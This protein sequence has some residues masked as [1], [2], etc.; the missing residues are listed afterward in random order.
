MSQVTEYNP[1]K[2]LWQHPPDIIIKNVPVTYFDNDKDANDYY[3]RI[4]NKDIW[5]TRTDEISKNFNPD[6]LGEFF[7]CLKCRRLEDGAH[8]RIIAKEK[9]VM[10]I[11]VRTGNDCY[12]NYVKNGRLIRGDST[13][14]ETYEKIMGEIKTEHRLDKKWLEVSAFDKW[15]FILQ[16]VDF[17]DK[18]FLDV[19][20][21]VGYSCFRAWSLMAS[22]VVGI[23]IRTDVL[24]VAASM[25]EKLKAL[26][27][28]I[29]FINIPLS[30]Y[31]GGHDIVMCM[32]LLHYFPITDYEKNFP[33][34]N[35]EKM[36]NSLIE[37]C[38]ETLIIELRLRQGDKNI[39]LTTGTGNQ[40]LPTEGWLY[41]KLENNNFVIKAK[42]NRG[43]DR[44]LWI[45]KRIDAMEKGR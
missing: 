36:I 4:K 38:N 16:H 23:D 18:S 37:S 22:E 3:K 5:K 43:K 25:N 31:H 8:R 7:Y 15:P 45:A 9:G 2:K 33:I 39:K 12:K 40:T 11:D 1:N 35:Y 41:R 24:C 14:L 26:N 29:T 21:N 20:C 17:R 10:A 19:G 32:G 6:K 30:Q 28:K 13:F 42:Y 44:E 34:A 27:S